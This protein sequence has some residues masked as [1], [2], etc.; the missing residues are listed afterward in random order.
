MPKNTHEMVVNSTLI[1]GR[2][3]QVAFKGYCVSIKRILHQH[4]LNRPSV[5]R[6]PYRSWNT[7][8]QAN[9]RSKIRH[10]RH[11]EQDLPSNPCTVC[12]RK[13]ISYTC[14]KGY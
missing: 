4:R 2:K 1:I 8:R 6:P 14:H 3:P 12:A 5:T 11:F 9:T 7:N 10:V 13:G